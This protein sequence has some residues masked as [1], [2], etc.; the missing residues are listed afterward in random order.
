VKVEE[1]RKI[2][3]EELGKRISELRL[4]L[5]KELGSIRMGRPVKNS[6]KVKELRRA[7]ARIL[8]VQNELKGKLKGKKK[9]EKTEN[10][11]RG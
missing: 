4:E 10:S 7:I 11:K 2:K 5:A 8:T 6:G 1:A 3:P 9:Q